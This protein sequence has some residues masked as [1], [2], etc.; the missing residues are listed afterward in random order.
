MTEQP[1]MNMSE[2]TSF[3]DT[4]AP[5]YD[6]MTGFG[7][8]FVHERPFFQMLVDRHSIK[9]ALDAGCGTG[10]HS[11]LLAQLGVNVTAVD[12]SSSMLHGLRQHAKEMSFQITTNQSNF[13]DLPKKLHDKFDAVFCMGNTLA[14]MQSAA[15]LQS[16]LSAFRALLKPGGVLFAQT[17]NYDRIVK[18]RD[19]IQSVKEA[20]GKMFVRWYEYQKEQILFHLLKIEK[21]TSGLQHNLQ[22]VRLRPVLRD[23]MQALLAKANF[24]DV[25]VYGS[26]AMERY[27]E[28]ASKDL[29]VLAQA[30]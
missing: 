3:Y 5:D 10:F 29:V 24:H 23:E 19:V 25:G 17:L 27:D 15:E 12:V 1:T 30:V 20:D 28:L 4:L 11:L 8:R 21:S 14:H 26:V 7:Q 16:V 6:T 22:T 2:V 18:V 9:S 13:E